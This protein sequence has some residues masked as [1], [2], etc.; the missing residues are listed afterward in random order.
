MEPALF[1]PMVANIIIILIGT[2]SVV[3][4]LGAAYNTSVSIG[5]RN[6][7]KKIDKMEQE[8]KLLQ[9]ELK[10]IKKAHAA[11]HPAIEPV[12]LATDIAKRTV[13]APQNRAEERK[14]QPEV[15]Q[16]FVDDYNNLSNSMNVPKAVEACEKFVRSYKLELLIC[17][18]AE[19]QATV[20]SN[21]EYTQA[22]NVEQSRFWAWNVIGQPEDF[23]VVPN[24][25]VEYDEKSH[26]QGG[27]K[28]TFASNYESG[29]YQQVQV[30]LPAH[31][32]RHLGKWKIVQPGVI[33]LK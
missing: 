19:T 14:L 20:G 9:Q 21:P 4:L 2:L 17:I 7:I 10:E 32:T 5:A 8:M 28:E 29:I 6:K 33:R 11:N 24:P 1:S 27:M 22:D 30:K 13:N 26:Q 31:F 3:A 15:W 18:E 12:P 16:K 23:A 25:L